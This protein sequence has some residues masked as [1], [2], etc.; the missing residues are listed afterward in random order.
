MIALL[1]MALAAE[2]RDFQMVAVAMWP[3]GVQYSFELEWREPIFENPH[4]LLKNSNVGLAIHTDLT[5]SFW[6]VG[7]VLKLEPVAFWDVSIRLYGTWFYGTFSSII[8]IEDPFETEATAAWKKDHRE[9]RVG[10]VGLRVEGNTRFKIK[11]GPV[12]AVAELEA[13]YMEVRPW[14]GEVEYFWDPTE[15]LDVKLHGWTFHRNLL[16]AAILQEGPGDKKLWLGGILNWATC[17][18]TD[19]ENLRAGPILWWKP[20]NQRAV[21]NILLASQGWWI[22]SF[23]EPLPPY[24]WLALRWGNI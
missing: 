24:T 21:P 7:P 5:P 13:R 18:A 20:N 1:S 8:P 22:S 15:M 2:L 6:R 9:L 10:G 23:V 11:A 16:V 14:R 19:D 4:M 12:V 17:P 3:A